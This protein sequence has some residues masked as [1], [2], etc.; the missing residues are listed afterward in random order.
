MKL[1]INGVEIPSTVI[2]TSSIPTINDS[3]T[4]VRISG[5]P[6]SYPDD[7][8]GQID[9]ATIFSRVLSPTEIQAI[10]QQ[11]NG[12]LGDATV[13]FQ[14]VTTAGITEQIPL[15]LSTLPSL[16][17]GSTA[18]GLAYDISTTAVYTGSPQVCFNLPSF[19]NSVVFNNLRILHLEGGIWQ[20]R[21]DILSI[22]FASKTICT[23]G[24]NSLSPFAVV[25]GFAPT[26]ANATISGRVQT[27]NGRG[28]SNVTVELTNLLNGETRTVR[29]NNFGRYSFTDLETGQNY[30][31]S[32]T[33]KRFTFTNSS[34]LITLNE[35][36]S[37]ADFIAN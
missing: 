30:L 17:S 1:F 21:T 36:L 10:Y 22:D 18:T 32:V 14:N 12:S 26:A 13:T 9:E 27:A 15:D 35:S 3:T 19:T 28:I 7:F 20:N 2:S 29:T 16:P 6:E 23:T 34:R 24:L 8:D 11:G 37:D 25:N 4:P 33:A 31:L 5:N